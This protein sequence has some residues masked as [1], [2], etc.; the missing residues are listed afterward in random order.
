MV[1]KG[2]VSNRIFDIFNIILM[3]L[4]VVIMIY[5]IL[6]VIFASF[7]SP[8]SI[9]QAHGFLLYPKEPHLDAYRIVFQNPSILR[10]YKNTLFFVL[11]GTLINLVMTSLGAYVLSRKNLLWKKQLTVVI[12]FTMYFSGG[13]I[14]LFLTVKQLGLMYSRSSILFITAI[15]TWNLM[16]M[17][18]A[19]QGVPEELIESAK[20]DGAQDFTILVRIIVPLSLPTIAVMALFYGVRRWNSW[21]YETIFLSR[22]LYP[23]QVILQEILLRNTNVDYLKAVHA[24][25]MEA[26]RYKDIIKYA[27][28]VV[29]TIPILFAYPLLQRYFVKG[30]MIGSLKG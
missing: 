8:V 18:T 14:P 30:I 13:L 7:S 11:F 16:V 24:S 1:Q 25:Q 22:D 3:A 2:S 15:N 5:P 23:L 27:V 4:I 20:M 12:L 9:Y 6:F 28:I 26:M 17:K 19:F 29:S 21:F 10:G